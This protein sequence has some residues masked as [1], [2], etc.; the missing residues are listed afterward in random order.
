M[1]DIR[2]LLDG[3]VVVGI[4]EEDKEGQALFSQLLGILEGDLANQR[5]TFVGSPNVQLVITEIGNRK[6]FRKRN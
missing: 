3:L 4:V 6:S 1:D 5:S 2:V